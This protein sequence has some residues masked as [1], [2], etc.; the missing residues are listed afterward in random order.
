LQ[1]I[2]A[3]MTVATW[4]IRYQRVPVRRSDGQGD[5]GGGKE[6]EDEKSDSP[7]IR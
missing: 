1:A 4:R 6:E 2:L 7:W 5:E 3:M